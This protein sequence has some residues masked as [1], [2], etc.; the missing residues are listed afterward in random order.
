[1]GSIKKKNEKEFGFNK[2]FFLTHMVLPILPVIAIS[3]ILMIAGGDFWLTT[4]IYKYQGYEWRLTDHWIAA[5]ILHKGGKNVSL[6]ALLILIAIVCSSFFKVGSSFRTWRLPLIYLSS[7]VLLCVFSIGILKTVTNMDCPWSLAEFGGDRPFV[8]LFEHRPS[9][10]GRGNCFP[11]GHASAGYAW[12]GLY[13]FFLMSKPL[14]RWR[15]LAIGIT[16]GLIFGLTQQLRGAHFI[17]HDLW[18]LAICWYISALTYIAFSLK[19]QYRV[20]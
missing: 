2:P 17:S 16:L 15:G 18:A 7:S 10:I 13:F 11:A 8:G 19:T 5:N 1:M 3:Y 12:I 20:G 6:T 9:S 4:K 14:F